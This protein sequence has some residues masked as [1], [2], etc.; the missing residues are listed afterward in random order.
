MGEDE[1]RL[2]SVTVPPEV[3][4]YKER[5]FF[6]L[7]VRQMVC[8][9][10]GLALAVPTGIFGG[11]IM[12]SDMVQWVVFLEAAP[13][14]AIG[15]FRYNDM[16]LEKIAGKVFSHYVDKQKYKQTYTEDIWKLQNEFTAIMLETDKVLYKVYK[17][18]AKK[19]AKIDRKQAKK[20]VKLDKK[21]SKIDRK[22]A[23][24]QAKLQKREARRKK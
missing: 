6:G 2:V 23:K 9:A 12:S 15:F 14:L 7:T 1:K 10:A 16:P 19:Q 17:K 4:E 18:K 24:K 3:T 13:F 20:Q 11:R 5:F 21:Q 22:N 8:V